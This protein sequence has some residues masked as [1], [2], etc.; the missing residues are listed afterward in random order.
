MNLETI[1]IGRNLPYYLFSKNKF[2]IKDIVAQRISYI[3]N[4][5]VQVK[6]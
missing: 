6:F 5:S 4:F 2:P 1:S 3:C